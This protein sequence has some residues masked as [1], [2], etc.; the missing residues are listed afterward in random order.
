MEYT[1]HDRLY[2]RI[3]LLLQ[4]TNQS[5]SCAFGLEKHKHLEQVGIGI[6]SQKVGVGFH[7]LISPQLSFAFLQIS[8]G[9]L[10][11]LYH[12]CHFTLLFFVDQDV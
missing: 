9:K 7:D 11:D 4:V 12:S 5:N 3:D 1:V 8:Q 6:D 10:L 2:L